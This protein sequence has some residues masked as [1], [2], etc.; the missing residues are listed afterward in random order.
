MSCT[1]WRYSVCWYIGH[2]IVHCSVE[3]LYNFLKKK[4]LNTGRWHENPREIRATRVW[5]RFRANSSQPRPPRLWLG[6]PVCKLH[7]KLSMQQI[8]M[9]ECQINPYQTKGW[10]HSFMRVSTIKAW[11][12]SDI[13]DVKNKANDIH[14]LIYIYLD[15][16]LAYHIKP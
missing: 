12:D 9:M 14:I 7:R 4:W 1:G 2:N 11:W 5:V 8:K 16:F 3:K 15:I 13:S 6:P 10:I